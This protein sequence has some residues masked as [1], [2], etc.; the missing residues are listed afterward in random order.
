V[1]TALFLFV[2]ADHIL[3]TYTWREGEDETFCFNNRTRGVLWVY[4]EQVS[5]QTVILRYGY[6]HMYA[7]IVETRN[8]RIEVKKPGKWYTFFPPSDYPYKPW[9]KGQVRLLTGNRVLLRMKKRPS[10]WD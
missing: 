8:V 3:N 1:A 10:I 6:S 9:Y 4:V 7:G 2:V 5:G